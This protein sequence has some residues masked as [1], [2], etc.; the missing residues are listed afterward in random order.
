MDLVKAEDMLRALGKV[1]D[2]QD[3]EPVDIVICG[4]MALLMRGMVNRSTRDIDSLGLVEER[5]GVMILRKPLFSAELR[6]A[7]ERVGNL[8]GE[9]KNWLSSAA[10]VLHE[11]TVLPPDIITESEARKFGE[12]LTVRVCSRQHLVFLKLWG[13]INRGEPDIGDLRDMGVSEREAREAAAWCLDQDPD[14]LPRI[15]TVLEVIGHGETAR[16]LGKGA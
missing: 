13:A 11:D 15:V 3:L 12:R 4:A 1:L 10:I 5:K 8:Y 9:G 2:F 16:R 14:A 6:A 7:V